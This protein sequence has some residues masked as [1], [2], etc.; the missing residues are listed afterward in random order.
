LHVKYIY[1]GLQNWKNAFNRSS[2]ISITHYITIKYCGIHFPVSSHN[3]YMYNTRYQMSLSY[4]SHFENQPL[5]YFRNLK[6]KKVDFIKVCHLNRRNHL[7]N[8]YYYSI[9]P[10]KVFLKIPHKSPHYQYIVGIPSL[11]YFLWISDQ[12]KKR[13]TF[14]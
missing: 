10:K 9:L 7:N 1:C 14:W 5:S 13:C 12:W 3:I 8:W 4:Y 11:Y 2:C 6:I